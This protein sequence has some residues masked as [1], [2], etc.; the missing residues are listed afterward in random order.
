MELLQLRLRNVGVH[1]FEGDSTTRLA[2]LIGV[3][4]AQ[5]ANAANAGAVA[6]ASGDTT[7][8]AASRQGGATGIVNGVLARGAKITNGVRLWV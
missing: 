5:I 8:S 4:Q 7:G 6:T 2:R 1:L 3:R